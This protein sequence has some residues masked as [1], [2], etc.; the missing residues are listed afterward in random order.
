MHTA[1]ARHRKPCLTP[2]PPTMV[3][4]SRPSGHTEGR[5]PRAHLHVQHGVVDGPLR[6]RE[7]GSCRE[8]AR[9]VRRVAPAATRGIRVQTALQKPY[10]H[11]V[12]LELKAP[13]VLTVEAWPEQQ[14]AAA[15]QVR[16]LTYPTC[17]LPDTALIF[18]FN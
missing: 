9:D 8:R 14:P 11:T 15:A 7:G 5:A 12:A 2:A 6:R 13:G 1:A 18:L 16:C 17:L 4:L 10:P 3:Q